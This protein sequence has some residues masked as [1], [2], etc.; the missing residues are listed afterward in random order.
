MADIFIS[1]AR[2]DRALVRP[3]AD[4]LSAHGWS[5]WWDRQIRTGAAF[6]QVIAEELARARCVVVV[7]SHRSVASSW[8]REEAEEGRR[9]GILIPVLIDEARP[10]L[11][12]GRIQAADLR[13]WTGAEMSEAFQK[14]I[15]DIT[16]IV[17]S[18]HVEGT[19]TASP[20]IERESGALTS[21]AP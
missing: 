14:L 13:D 8:V 11:G 2:E 12:F 9:R 3:I 18:T 17:G 15:A 16:A 6:D 21:G 10:P 1:Y 19:A 20:S 5:V 7:W 4:A